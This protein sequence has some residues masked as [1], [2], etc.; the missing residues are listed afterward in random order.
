MFLCLFFFGGAT[1]ANMF[2]ARG[3]GTLDHKFSV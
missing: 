2:F 1:L 3:L